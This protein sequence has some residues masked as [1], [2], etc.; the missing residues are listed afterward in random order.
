MSDDNQARPPRV[1]VTGLWASKTNDGV[2]YFAGNNGGQRWT[3]WPNNYRN[4]NGKAPTHYLYLEN[5]PP[6]TDGDGANGGVDMSG[7]PLAN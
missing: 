7:V 1:R 4:G 2:V 5:P 3:I 6:K